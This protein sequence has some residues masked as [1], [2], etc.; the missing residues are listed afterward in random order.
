MRGRHLNTFK[1]GKSTSLKFV[2]WCGAG[3][4][5]RL[6]LWVI[7]SAALWLWVGLPWCSPYLSCSSPSSPGTGWCDFSSPWVSHG[8]SDFC[9][10]YH[11]VKHFLRASLV[12]CGWSSAPSMNVSPC[13]IIPSYLKS[14]SHRSNEMCWWNTTG[15]IC[16]K[17]DW[18][19]HSSQLLFLWTCLL[20]SSL[21]VQVYLDE[22][23]VIS[24]QSSGSLELVALRLHVISPLQTLLRLITAQLCVPRSP[25][26]LYL[27]H[28]LHEL[29]FLLKIWGVKQLCCLLGF[30]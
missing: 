1:P 25:V 29:A 3:L 21:C 7:S 26:C 11:E 27:Q 30:A 15:I 14:G 5:E 22:R 8:D 16:L 19:Q 28:K 6:C 10:H 24:Q 13:R 17:G 12:L 20:W 23:D 2:K 9:V 18:S 4:H